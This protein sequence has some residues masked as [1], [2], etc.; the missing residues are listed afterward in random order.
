[1]KRSFLALP[2]GLLLFGLAAH[3]APFK[4]LSSFGPY[5]A[6]NGFPL[7]Y[8]VLVETDGRDLRG[9]MPKLSLKAS[10]QAQEGALLPKEG[11][12]VYPYSKT[13]GLLQFLFVVPEEQRGGVYTFSGFLEWAK[14][15]RNRGNDSPSF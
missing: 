1:M 8:N 15:R 11:K 12:W 9:I 6:A 5:L 13:K 3:G 4:V 14:C 10:Y 2:I 7:T